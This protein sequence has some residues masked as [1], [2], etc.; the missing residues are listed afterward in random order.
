K[1]R[2]HRIDMENK[3][4]RYDIKR[5]IM[6]VKETEWK[7]KGPI[8]V[9]VTHS[10]QE[11]G[12]IMIEHKLDYTPVVNALDEPVGIVTMQSILKAFLQ[13]QTKEIS[14]DKLMEMQFLPIYSTANMTEMIASSSEF[15][16]VVNHDGKL[17]GV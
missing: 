5:W 17:R 16:V 1:N 6:L 15:I 9:K 12:Q 7:G 14:V 2:R 11:A 13:E 10:I 3:Y 8:S 4:D